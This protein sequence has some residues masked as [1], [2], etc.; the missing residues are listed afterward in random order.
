MSRNDTML[1][2]L[3]LGALLALAGCEEG[4]RSGTT[5]FTGGTNAQ[6]AAVDGTGGA[7]GSPGTQGGQGSG[8]P[9]GQALFAQNCAGCHG[10][11]GS[12]G[13]VWARTIRELKFIEETVRFGVGAMPAFDRLSS[14]EI[15]AI[16]AYLGGASFPE[17]GA[18][19]GGGGDGTVTAGYQILCAGCHGT[20]GEGSDLGPQIQSPVVPYATWVVRN[21]REGIGYPEA[22]PQYT[23]DVLS[24]A[25]LT[26]MLDT[27]AAAP[28][29]TTDEGIYAR[30]CGNCHGATG[31][32]GPTRQGILGELGELA[33]NVRRGRS[34]GRYGSRRSYMPAW[35][36]AELTS[37]D[38]SAIRRFLLSVGGRS[39]GDG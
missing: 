21:G 18:G 13:A 22:M 20:N 16:E 38:L 19:G 23:A 32:G 3:M 1:A 27:L 11:D 37:A 5:G 33:E 39:G 26:E 9:N 29:P 36:S 12:G 25:T 2:A 35:S 15:L 4:S 7:Q 6:G 24:D 17:G 34:R 28:K 14:S 8:A 30:Y 10:A 31:R